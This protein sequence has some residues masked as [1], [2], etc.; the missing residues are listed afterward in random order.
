MAARDREERRRLVELVLSESLGQPPAP[1][2]DAQAVAQYTNPYSQ[3]ED[4]RGCC[5][6]GD[7]T[8]THDTETD[9]HEEAH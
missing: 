6:V 5:G 1:P 9:S 3:R 2:D 4:H 7:E 8:H